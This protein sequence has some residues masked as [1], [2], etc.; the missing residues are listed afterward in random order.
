MDVT[1]MISKRIDTILAESQN[2][3]N[4]IAR[5]VEEVRN[6]GDL[7]ITASSPP[8]FANQPLPVPDLPKEHSVSGI[9]E[10]PEETLPEREIKNFDIT[11][12]IEEI[13]SLIQ[14]IVIDPPSLDSVSQTLQ[15]IP[16]PGIPESLQNID[17][18][19]LNIPDN[20]TIPEFDN[21]DAPAMFSIPFQMKDL[22]GISELEAK[23]LFDEI[24]NILNNNLNYQF[25]LQK[26]IIGHRSRIDEIVTLYLT[27]INLLKTQSPYERSRQ[28]QDKMNFILNE[29][30]KTHVDPVYLRFLEGAPQSLKSKLSKLY[31]QAK[32]LLDG[33]VSEDFFSEN[34]FTDRDKEDQLKK[35]IID[36]ESE[37]DKFEETL[38]S[39]VLSLWDVSQNYVMLYLGKMFMELSRLY[40][41]EILL[42]GLWETLSTM[43]VTYNTL[44]KDTMS[45]YYKLI[46]QKANTNLQYIDTVL[47][48]NDSRWQMY[49]EQ[50]NILKSIVSKY[51]EDVRSFEARVANAESQVSISKNRLSL[52][53]AKIELFSRAVNNA[54]QLY[55][56]RREKLSSIIE[57]GRL[58]MDVERL[59]QGYT[60]EKASLLKDVQDLHTSLLETDIMRFR[61]EFNKW[62]DQELAKYRL[63]VRLNTERSRL[64]LNAYNTFIQKALRHTSYIRASQN[65]IDNF[66]ERVSMLAFSPLASLSNGLHTSIDA[67][68]NGLYELITNA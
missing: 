22:V 57:E 25:Y 44:Y 23:P 15:D 53:Q 30:V 59:K 19:S 34:V 16:I 8:D 21:V 46:L 3:T 42:A 51:S 56:L 36:L 60:T 45:N 61:Y 26:L 31:N 68:S 54:K 43:V 29:K 63:A 41:K 10:I 67:V 32:N 7:I 2:T 1:D 4:S 13:D 38:V 50:M 9:D 18:P 37:L 62:L 11:K 64:L 40:E 14:D 33:Q 20:V 65:M 24:E 6:R 58:D 47:S 28:A 48:K 55:N 5:F 49:L 35:L 39:T 66:S 12:Y 17:T 27:L 52:N